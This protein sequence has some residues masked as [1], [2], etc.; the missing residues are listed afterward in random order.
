MKRSTQL[1]NAS[2]KVFG[3]R[4]RWDVW[5]VALAT[6]LFLGGGLAGLGHDH[7]HEAGFG[8]VCSTCKI[9]QSTTFDSGGLSVEPDF[10]APRQLEQSADTAPAQTVSVAVPPLRGPPAS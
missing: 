3:G 6:A 7:G 10:S 8:H 1:T 2:A 4:V 5:L 9:Q